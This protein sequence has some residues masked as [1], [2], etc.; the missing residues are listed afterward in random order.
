MDTIAA[1]TYLAAL[2]FLTSERS[3][4]GGDLVS[5]F[6]ETAFGET[7]GVSRLRVWREDCWTPLDVLILRCLEGGGGEKESSLSSR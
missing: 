5:F 6:T 7:F 2:R 4:F 3:G 1:S